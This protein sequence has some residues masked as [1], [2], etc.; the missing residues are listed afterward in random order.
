MKCVGWVCKLPKD[1]PQSLRYVILGTKLN[2]LL[3]FVPLAMLGVQLN[4]GHGWVF[5]LS[6]L[7]MAPL[8]ER[9]GFV[10]E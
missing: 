5:L 2:V 10:T 3:L 1:L 4:F 8:A 6:L 7:G 9:L